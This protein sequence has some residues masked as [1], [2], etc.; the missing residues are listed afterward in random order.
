ML[1]LF[2]IKSDF[3]TVTA[4]QLGATNFSGADLPTLLFVEK[5]SF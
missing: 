3:V 4:K 5:E 2:I 1:V